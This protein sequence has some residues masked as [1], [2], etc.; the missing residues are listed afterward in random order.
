MTTAKLNGDGRLDFAIPSG[1][2][3][4]TLTPYLGNGDGTFRTGTA[5]QFA[6]RNEVTARILDGETSI[7]TQARP[8]QI[9]EGNSFW[10]PN[11]A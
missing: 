6:D 10:T 7:A 5:P 2:D 3:S 1:S 11:T 9:C 4:H 8:V